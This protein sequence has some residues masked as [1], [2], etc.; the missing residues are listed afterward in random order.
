MDGFVKSVWLFFAAAAIWTVGEIVINTGA[1]AFIAANSPA[2]HV[3]RFQS[4]LETCTAAGK[5]VSPILYG[6][7]LKV[8]S[9]EAGWLMNAC[10]CIVISIF[11]GV[12]YRRYAVP[13]GGSH[14]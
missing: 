8:A 13:Q 4:A 1:A 2:T 5:T 12:M 7:L 6:A 10:V 3:A 14:E 11:L 9:Y